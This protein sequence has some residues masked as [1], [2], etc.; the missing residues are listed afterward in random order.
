VGRVSVGDIT[1]QR[2]EVVRSAH[3]IVASIACDEATFNQ[4][5]E[6]FSGFV[7]KVTRSRIDFYWKDAA[8][9]KPDEMT[10]NRHGVVCSRRLFEGR[11]WYG[12]TLDPF[13][14]DVSYSVTSDVSK[15]MLERFLKAPLMAA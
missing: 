13:G 14:E 4:S 12:Y 1:N 5:P 11:N 3:E 2:A 9:G 7:R 6:K 10:I 15:L 8:S